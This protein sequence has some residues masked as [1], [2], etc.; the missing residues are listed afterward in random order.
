MSSERLLCLS[1]CGLTAA[2]LSV[3][4]YQEYHPEEVRWAIQGHLPGD[5]REVHLHSHTEDA[6]S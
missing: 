1:V 3:L 5:L 4:I 6:D 2:L